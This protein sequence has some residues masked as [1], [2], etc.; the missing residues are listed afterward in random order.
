MSTV[1][2]IDLGYRHIDT[3]QMYGNEKGVVRRAALPTPARYR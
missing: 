1:P 3:A 2:T